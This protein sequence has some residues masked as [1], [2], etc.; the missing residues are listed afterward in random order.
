MKM[1]DPK[2]GVTISNREAGSRLYKDC[3]VG[4]THRRFLVL[5]I[6]NNF[7]SGSEMVAWLKKETNWDAKQCIEFGQVRRPFR[8]RIAQI[9]NF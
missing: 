5:E 7:I 6:V 8:S 9:P 2:H 1:A 4:P 3:F